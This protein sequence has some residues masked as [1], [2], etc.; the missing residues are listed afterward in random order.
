MCQVWR[1]NGNYAEFRDVLI[2]TSHFYF[3]IKRGIVF[4]NRQ[5]CE[6]NE[7]KFD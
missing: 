5:G 4:K 2:R 7:K 1:I 3:H 6:I